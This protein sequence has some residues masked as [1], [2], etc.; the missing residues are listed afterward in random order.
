MLLR[1]SIYAAVLVLSAPL[2]AAVPFNLGPVEAWLDTELGY[3]EGWSTQSSNAHL[4]GANN[5]GLGA[6]T[7]ADDGRLNYEAGSS[8]VRQ[9]DLELAL[10]LRYAD[11]G[12]YVRGLT[13]NDFAANGTEPFR[14]I[15]NSGRQ[16]LAQD[17]GAQLLE[18]FVYQHYAVAEQPGQLR[19]G[20]QVLGWG[21]GLFVP[22][23]VQAINP[24]QWGVTVD[25]LGAVDERLLPSDLLYLSQRLADRW[26]LDG[27]LQGRAESVPA[28]CATFM[29]GVDGQSRGCT[30]SVALLYTQQQVAALYGPAAL[31]N[32]DH[33]GVRWGV[34][35]EG[36]LVARAPDQRA[37]KTGQ[38][39]IGVHYFANWLDTHVAF[40][41][42]QT[43]SREGYLGVRAPEQ[44]V[45]DAASQQGVLAPL[46]V[47]GN[48]VYQMHYPQDIRTYALS[49]SS[50]L[51]RGTLWS[52]ELS[53]RPNAPLQY[54]QVD[55]L[56]AP[57]TPLD[58]AQS[59]LALS[60]GHSFS[61][62]NRK[63]VV[64]VQ[65][66]LSQTFDQAMGAD[67]FTLLGELIGVQV[68]DLEAHAQARYGRDPAYGAGTLPED[69]CTARN[70][71]NLEAAGYSGAEAGRY[72]SDEG[73]VTSTAW[74][75]RA[76][77]IW[78]FREVLPKVTLAPSL[79]FAEDVAGYGPN[80]LLNE[81]VQTLTLG[82]RAEY[83]N[84]YSAQLQATQWMGGTFSPQG[85]RDLILL[86]LALT[87]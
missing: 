23:A 11:S 47:A 50:R 39:G 38:W 58:V 6:S 7:L 33:L 77:A 45:Y 40:Y 35:D 67:Q 56:F 2:M 76:K 36:V 51:P 27:F 65:T 9:L 41:A 87:L 46:V 83:Q 26:M 14:N 1:F 15:S 61:G 78:S 48:S 69:A 57:Q 34:P 60:A 30:D 13:W 86:R 44:A 37:P 59:P 54:N 84:I 10:E 68:N 29:A 55:V 21:E 19:V 85:D 66:Q 12:A 63:G 70:A 53:Y 81:G 82:L 42:L 43:H 79:A 3:T 16:P 64:Q 31:T 52:G 25:P 17:S 22:S 72:C 5:G 20:R 75:Y 71:A 80:N 24:Q 28:N 8:I 73:F 32:L 18:A 74:G 4:I 49:F 62:Y